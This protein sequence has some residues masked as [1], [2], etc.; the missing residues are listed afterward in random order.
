MIQLYNRDGL[1]A[2]EVLTRVAALFEAR[3]GEGYGDAVGALVDWGNRTGDRRE[4]AMRLK[5]LV[6]EI[7]TQA[8]QAGK[9][10]V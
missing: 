1:E 2:V 6:T 7:R 9:A 8:G 3:A 5:A 10:I 4:E